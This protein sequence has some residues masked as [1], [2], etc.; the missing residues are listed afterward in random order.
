M[1]NQRTLS[2][3]LLL[4]LLISLLASGCG[5]GAGKSATPTITSIPKVSTEPPTATPTLLPTATSTVSPTSTPT[6]SPSPTVD[7]TAIAAARA[8][9]TSEAVNELIRPDL[10]EYGVDPADGKVV[11]VEKRPVN[12]ELTSY[13]E[14]RNHVLEEAGKL[15]D[16][17]IQS[18]IT[19]ETSGALA[20]CGLTFRAE[21]DLAMGAQDRFFMMRL[22][23]DPGWTIWRWEYGKYQSFVSDWLSSRDIH[24][25]NGS[26]NVVALV[27]QGKDID[28][29]I[30]HDK[31]RRVEDSKLTE[32]LLALSAF[33]ESGKTKC[34][35]ENTW[36]WAF[37]H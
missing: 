15:S 30:N 27:V 20:L 24:D 18:D 10:E 4:A 7:R 3:F 37:D 36:V 32:G 9:D 31:Q 33:Q 19:W 12:L 22:Q 34:K 26:T 21:D 5:Q 16:F 23:F 8:T 35:F 6:P 29:F 11:W 13:M 14:N 25:K 1:S 17:V 28:V 2:L